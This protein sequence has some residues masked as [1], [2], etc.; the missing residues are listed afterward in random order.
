MRVAPYKRYAVS[1]TRAMTSRSPAGPK[2]QPVG[3]PKLGAKKE[4]RRYLRRA[5]GG[6]AGC[7]SGGLQAAARRRLQGTEKARLLHAQH[8]RSPC[9][10]LFSA[11]E[12][13]LIQIQSSIVHVLLS[14]FCVPYHLLCYMLC[15]HGMQCQTPLMPKSGEDRVVISLVSGE[16]D[17]SKR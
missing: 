11:R 15:S 14:L 5:S 3:P 6:R 4:D 10:V 2:C 17:S 9:S 16:D 1:E 8:S 12:N 7:F 13:W